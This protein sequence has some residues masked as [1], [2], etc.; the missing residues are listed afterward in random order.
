MVNVLEHCRDAQRVFDKILEI[1][2]QGGTLVFSEPTWPVDVIQSKA[3]NEFDA[4]HPLRVSNDFVCDF[5]S[6]NFTPLYVHE[7]YGLYDQEG[8]QDIYYIGRKK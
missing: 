6:N 4:G 3:A 1:T 5:L 2:A 8:R 7:F